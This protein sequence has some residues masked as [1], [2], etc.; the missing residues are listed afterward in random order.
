MTKIDIE[1]RNLHGLQAAVAAFAIVSGSKDKSFMVM[2]RLRASQALACLGNSELSEAW[3]LSL[4]KGGAK[5]KKSSLFKVCLEDVT[6]LFP[7]KS[8]FDWDYFPA[9]KTNGLS[10]LR[11]KKLGNELVAADR[12]ELALNEYAKG[13]PVDFRQACA[14]ALS[15]R[16]AAAMK[17]KDYIQAIQDSTCTI[18]FDTGFDKAHNRRAIAATAL[19]WSKKV[20]DF[21]LL[22]I[23]IPRR[24]F[25]SIKESKGRVNGW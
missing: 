23:Q 17:E 7:E 11:Q 20:L 12:Y 22:R 18:F 19:D 25:R 24:F 21:F 14:K 16:A 5:A 10:L 2:A 3:S 4:N 6:K 15:N 9:K 1:G 8:L 13:F